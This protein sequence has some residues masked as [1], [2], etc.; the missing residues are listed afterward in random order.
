[1]P[2]K[3]GVEM[4]KVMLERKVPKENFAKLIGYLIDL[5]TAA[6]H[7]PGYVSGETLIKGENPVDVL[8]ISTWISEDH[9][10]A[11]TTTEQ[12]IDLYNMIDRL[13]IGDMKVNIYQVPSGG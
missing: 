11:W 7:Q 8:V 9:W 1:M 6:L 10:K 2:I 12:R 13:L 5:R 3:G 4:I